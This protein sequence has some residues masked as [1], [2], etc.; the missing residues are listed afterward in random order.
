M[1]RWTQLTLAVVAAA[2]FTIGCAG[3]D[4]RETRT[5][6][7]PPAV[8]TS[9][10]NANTRSDAD[11]SWVRDQLEDGEAE[12][13]LGRLASEK[14]RHPQVKEFAEMM[15]RDH[16]KAGA[17]LKQAAG[18][19]ATADA[20]TAENRD[21]DHKDLHERLSKL[22]G[23][24]FDREYMKAMIDEH[25]EAVNELEGK[26]KDADNAQIKDWA[27]KTLQHVQ[28]HLERAKQI[29]QTLEQSSR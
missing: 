25:E 21:G 4:G 9:G 2:G 14:A 29:Q 17:E 11:A 19:Q 8:G 20:R 26:A 13:M 6:G 5:D 24:E 22:S 7:N 15:V 18:A 16:T 27:G 28:H 23:A 10:A 3:D 1:K 12:V